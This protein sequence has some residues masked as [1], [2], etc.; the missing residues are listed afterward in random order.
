M[1]GIAGIIK[2][3]SQKYKPQLKKMTDSLSHRGPDAE[4]FYFFKD[5]GLGHRRLSIIDLKTG[6]QPMLS[7]NG[8]AGVV[9]NGEIYGYQEIKKNLSNYSFQTTSDTEVILALYEK[10]GENFV[11][12]LPGM[13]AFA[14]W[15]DKNKKLICARDRFGEKPLYYALGK[16][17]EFIFASEIKAILASDLI[18]PKLNKKSLIHYLKRLY[19]HPYSAIYENIYVLPPAHF[20]IYQN[21]KIKINRYWQMPELNYQI[22]FDEAIEKFKKLLFEA[23]KKQLV[24]DVPVGAFLSGGLDSSTIVAIASQYKK[25][26]N[27]FSFGFGEWINELPYALEIARKYK[28]NH[29]ELTPEKADLGELLIKMQE[30]YDEPFADSSNIPTYLLAKTARQYTKVV[31]TGDGGDEMLG[32][33]GWYKPFLFMNEKNSDLWRSEF[34]RFIARAIRRL[35]SSQLLMNKVLG[36]RFQENSCSVIEAH[37]SQNIIFNDNEIKALGLEIQDKNEFYKPSWKLVNSLDDIMRFDIENY[38]AGDILTKIDRAS[39]ANGLELRAPFLDV[40]FASFCL[41]LPFQ[42]KVSKD[43]DKIILRQAVSNLWTASIRKRSKQG[44]GGPVN[45]WL[46]Q[47]KSLK[48]LKENYLN[49]PK[50]KIFDLISFKNTREII[51]KNKYKTWTLLVLSLWMEKHDFE[52]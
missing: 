34:V 18:K 52:I 48:T 7:Y 43:N 5:C 20:L 12:H 33:Y 45:K 26:L 10:Y 28:T 49:N 2:K 37:L 11:K 35:S 16:N 41:S 4:G 51:K 29:T 39:M 40:D 38:M 8:Q 21:K 1:C 17:G 13:F 36:A 19:V 24:T 46:S 6:D 15:D 32:G 44:F 23:V 27:T 22:T 42:L 47:D 31:L 25:N 3:D 14:L 9:F 50:R 30:I